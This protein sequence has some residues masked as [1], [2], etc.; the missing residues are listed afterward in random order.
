[1]SKRVRLSR[2][3]AV[4][5]FTIGVGG[6][7]RP[8][9]AQ[10]ATGVVAG[11]ISDASTRR[12]VAGAQVLLVGTQQGVLAG[13]QGEFRIANVRPGRYDVRVRFVG[14]AAATQAVT[15]VA[16]QTTRADIALSQSLL[17]LTDVVV[18]GTG[19][20]TEQ[21]KLGNTVATVD[22]N[23]LKN[24]QINTVSEVLQ[25]REPGVAL[26]PSGGLSGEGARIRIRG[27]ASLS[28]SNEPIIYVD[29]VR[30]ES[31]G[32]FGRNIGTGGGGLPSRLDD[33][34]PQSIDRIE[35]L[36]GAAAATLYGTES[37]NGVIQ[38]FTKKGFAGAPRW[39]FHGEQGAIS[40]DRSRIKPNT[41]FARDTAQARRLSVF[42]G[43]PI[44]PFELIQQRSTDR[45]MKTGT[46]TTLDGSIS[47]GSPTITY[48]ASGRYAAEDGPFGG[49]S[50]GP[51]RDKT[52]KA[53]STLNLNLIPRSDLKIG[54][55]SF[56]LNSHAELPQNNNN[57]YA[58]FTLAQFSKPELANCTESAGGADAARLG[59]ASPGVCVGPGN[60][61]GSNA[62]GTVR[63]GMQETYK[64]DVER[65]TGS[66]N[67]AY[68]QQHQLV[69]EASAG[70]DFVA[71]RS[72]NFLPFGNNGDNFTTRNVGGQ[73]ALDAE[74]DRNI[75]TDS[76]ITWNA[77]LG[78]DWTTRLAAGGQVYSTRVLSSGGTNQQ[79]PGPFEVVGAGPKPTVAEYVLRQVTAG[80]FSEAQVGFRDF[81]FTTVGAR[82]DYASAFAESR[83]AVLYPK[84]SVSII[85]SDLAGYKE[86]QLGRLMPTLR[87]RGAIGRAGRQPGAFD[88]LTTYNPI[89]APSGGG[90]VPLNLGNADLRPE[91][92]EEKEVGTELGILDDRVGI[93]ATYWTRDVS[94]GLVAQ[95]FAPSGGFRQPQLVNI[96]QLSAHGYELGI[97]SVVVNRQSVTADLFVNGTYLWQ[98]VVKLG[99]PPLKVGGSYPRYRNYIREGYAPGSLFGAALPG[100]CNGRVS[101]PALPCLQPGQN[102]YDTNGDGVPDTDPVL[103]AF[104]AGPV[105]LNQL[106]PFLGSARGPGSLYDQYLGKPYPDWSGAFGGGLTVGKNWRLSTL[107]E[108][109]AGNY[110]VTNLTDAFRNSNAVIGRNTPLAASVEAVM[111]RPN[112]PAGQVANA[113]CSTPAA[114]L[115]AAKTWAYQLKAL[116]PFDG[117]NQNSNGDFVR[118]RELSVTYTLEPTWAARVGAREASIS[119]TGRNLKLWTR[120]DGVDPEIN[121]FSRSGGGGVNANFG[122]AIDAFGFP[123]P[124]RFSVSVR[125]GY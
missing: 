80:Y 7:A 44:A 6:G 111:E 39:A 66:L 71:Q 5:S 58:P 109:K 95:Q 53:Q 81:F 10:Q 82:Y 37:S 91:V 122:D 88:K 48:F 119:L 59:V 41:G 45:L 9:L 38:I 4:V 50:L 102:P 72:V 84:L 49:E 65:F 24:T 114:R 70:V 40:Y 121:V 69:L 106:D 68:N 13:S 89:S 79:F 105:K 64:Q 103:L 104:L 124:R 3:I 85:P 18:T 100:P 116:S 97:K 17:K 117:L 78:S 101:T 1:M 35:V 23:E 55:H 15:V 77:T 19:V 115:E 2:I 62:F 75:T 8:A 83:P 36:K 108:Y 43:R 60:P 90:L 26:L 33:I 110:T 92:S 11:T 96:G 123:I 56:Y 20:A 61:T 42:Y 28:Q 74:S 46:N 54:F 12:P 86:S 31:G 98:K 51:A 47:G 125:L 30:I 73:R 27:N 112:C 107:F 120:Y 87:L 14:Y 99:T 63:E 118:W 22:V 21:R 67:G 76:R 34:D 57:I 94:D 32:G 16:D 29:G 52:Q 113:A 93:V 25:G